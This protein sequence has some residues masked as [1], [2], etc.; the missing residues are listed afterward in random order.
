MIQNTVTDVLARQLWYH[1]DSRQRKKIVAN[2]MDKMWTA[3]VTESAPTT[4]TE[5]ASPFVLRA[6]EDETVRFCIEYL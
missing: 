5:E 2:E 1:K 3:G 4:E 6:K